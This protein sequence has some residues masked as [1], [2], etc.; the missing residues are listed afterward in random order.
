[1]MLYFRKVSMFLPILNGVE[2]IRSIGRNL[3]AASLFLLLGVA[4]QEAVAFGPST[5]PGGQFQ[6]QAGGITRFE[7]VSREGK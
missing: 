4:M 7:V 5:I 1:M 3:S 6:A 2:V